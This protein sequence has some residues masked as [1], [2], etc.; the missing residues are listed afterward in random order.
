MMKKIKIEKLNK[1]FKTIL[2]IIG[3]HAFLTSLVLIFFA[4]VTGFF[5]FYKYSI[6]A[7]K[8]ET[9]FEQSLLWL[10]EEALLEILEVAAE[11]QVRFKEAELKE[12][13]DFFQG[14]SEEKE[15]TE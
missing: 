13:P 7:E 12:F 10:E 3:K 15:L 5:I 9:E 2:R 14:P 11:R 1:D 6:L 8:E 4:L